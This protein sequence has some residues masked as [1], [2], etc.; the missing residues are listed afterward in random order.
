VA[1]TFNG[2][3]KTSGKTNS[4]GQY[5]AQGRPGTASVTIDNA[6]IPA[7]LIAQAGSYTETINLRAGKVDALQ[8]VFNP[9]SLSYQWQSSPD[10]TTWTNISGATSLSYTPP[11]NAV[12]S[13][14][15]RISITAVGNGCGS[16]ASTGTQVIVVADPSVSISTTN[17]SICL[18]SSYSFNAIGNGGTPSLTFQW[19]YNTGSSWQNVVNGTPN[20]A[21]YTGGTS[22]NLTISGLVVGTYQYQV[23]AAAI[24]NGCGPATSSA[25]TIQVIAPPNA[26]TGTTTTACKSDVSITTDLYTLLTG[27]QTGGTWTSIAPFPTGMTAASINSKITS[28]VVER[29]GFPVGTYTFRYTVIGTS[30]CPNDD[31]DVMITIDP[32]CPPSVCLPTSSSRF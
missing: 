10:N 27:E 7:G 1:V 30:P 26:G 21:V 2:G 15:Y 12:S 3:S 29:K 13:L 28:G 22:N 23:I 20:A 31:E 25:A 19:Q 16:V 9:P 5:F 14:Y 18:G 17:A 4:S 32:C 24:G 6:D 11:T 8:S